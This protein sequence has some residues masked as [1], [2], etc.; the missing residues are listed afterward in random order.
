M[1]IQNGKNQANYHIIETEAKTKSSSLNDE[2]K[3]IITNIPN[4]KNNKIKRNKIPVLNFHNPINH[5]QNIT[6]QKYFNINDDNKIIYISPNK[7]IYNKT[8]QNEEVNYT[9][10]KYNLTEVYL[11]NNTLINFPKN[12][13]KDNKEISYLNANEFINLKNENNFN[14][15]NDN[16]LLNDFNKYNSFK[17]KKGQIE[18]EDEYKKYTV[19]YRDKMINELN[20]K[21]NKDN[22]INES[23]NLQI[24]SPSINM[25][26]QNQTEKKLNLK[27]SKEYKIKK[28]K[29]VKYKINLDN[30]KYMKNSKK[31]ITINNITNK[32][33][34]NLD[35]NR[36]KDIKIEIIKKNNSKNKKSYLLIKDLLR[37]K[38]IKS[39]F[40]SYND[41]VL[42]IIISIFQI[43]I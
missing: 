39:N 11:K 35:K 34:N 21:L 20:K 26:D 27:C 40:L 1:L 32:N 33:I 7:K 16:N 36:I 19:S 29:F 42:S 5:F 10:K 4:K 9:N 22:I 28:L 12:N 30:K 38:V 18:E 15:I 6:K 14:I 43:H 2:N 3:S 25:I 23:F 8:I 37:N 13:M 31:K 41:I 24:D 17:S